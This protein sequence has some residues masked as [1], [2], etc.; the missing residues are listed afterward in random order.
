M[1]ESEINPS[2]L[3]ALRDNMSGLDSDKR[4]DAAG[5]DDVTRREAEKRHGVTDEETRRLQNLEKVTLALQGMLSSQIHVGSRQPTSAPTWVTLEVAQGGFATG[6]YLAALQ[7]GDVPNAAF[8]EGDGIRQLA[9]MLRSGCFRVRVPEHGALLVVV[10]LMLQGDLIEAENL[11]EKIAPWMQTLRFYPD[12][13]DTPLKVTPKVSIS[14]AGEVCSKLEFYTRTLSNLGI[15]RI[16]NFWDRDEA[17]EHWLPLKWRMLALFAETLPCEHIPSL[18]YKEPSIRP[19]WGAIGARGGSLRKGFG[20][21]P[22]PV[23]ASRR[24]K[25]PQPRPIQRNRGV[26]NRP[27]PTYV[28]YP[29]CP[30]YSNKTRECRCGWPCQHY[31]TDWIERATALVTGHKELMVRVYEESF[32]MKNPAALEHFDQKL[33]QRGA[34]YTLYNC[35]VKCT[36]GAGPSSLTGKEV[37]IIRTLL[38]GSNTKRGMPGT[39]SF[40][41]FW[42]PLADQR[43]GIRTTTLVCYDVTR[44]L[45][46]S[47]PTTGLLPPVLAS[48]LTPCDAGPVPN[49]V[50][51]KLE[52]CEMNTVEVLISKGKVPSGEVL[53]DLIPQIVAASTAIGCGNDQELARM[54]YAFHIAF[55]KR[56]SLLLLDL[57]KQVKINELP[58]VQIVK[59]ACTKTVDTRLM[60]R[61]TLEMVVT[62]YYKAFPQTII[63]NKLLQSLTVL[64]QNAELTDQCPITE[65][66]ALDI[67]EGRFSDKF[68]AAARVAANLLK[69][70]V[71]AR[72]YDLQGVYSDLLKVD[73]VRRNGQMIGDSTWFANKC[74]NRA[75]LRE[76]TDPRRCW[77]RPAENGLILEQQQIITTHN[78]A[79][80]FS[81][82]ELKNVLDCFDLAKRTWHWIVKELMSMPTEYINMLRTS[83][84]IAYAWRQ[85]LFYSTF[86]PDFSTVIDMLH[87]ELSF[88]ECPAAERQLLTDLILTP[89]ASIS[90]D[91]SPGEGEGEAVAVTPLLA[92]VTKKHPLIL[93]EL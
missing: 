19:D 60:F 58:W 48:L 70:S 50:Q 83:K 40:E 74:V 42:T 88:L 12:V 1:S 73:A 91:E 17:F 32:K 18:Q 10:W 67:F 23:H 72:Y 29:E 87:A 34:V 24:W 3:A 43:T 11:L 76:L 16:K 25:S 75:Q 78:L 6:R 27:A 53:A 36:K 66:L 2:Y 80:F 85:L 49:S 57:A 55:A 28:S 93:A 26:V 68:V 86:V 81:A 89:L 9:D 14:T 54:T 47:D 21:P 46:A 37:G 20:H 4:L 51:V 41:S 56:R 61:Q 90:T 5:A 45:A 59:D 38:A 31:P 52:A 64:V 30:Q 71:Y 92:F 44:R 65:E 69:D 15:S 22:A 8:L 82:L 7:D 13:A 39:K 79:S 84:N 63:V 62:L 77:R 33:K 35:L